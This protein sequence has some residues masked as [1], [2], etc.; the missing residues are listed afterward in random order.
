MAELTG[1]SH[2]VSPSQTP[3]A[4]FVCQW[5]SVCD[6]TGGLMIHWGS[7][8]REVMGIAGLTLLA[9]VV[10]FWGLNWGLPYLY[11]PDENVI[12]G[13]ALRMGKT[14]SL[15]PP[16]FA[17][18]PL[19]TYINLVFFGTWYVLARIVGV[20]PSPADFE[21]LYFTDPTWFYLIGRGINAT[22]GTAAIPLT[23]W[24]G[25]KLYGTAVGVVAALCLTFAFLHVQ[26]SHFATPNA[27]LP[28]FAV[29]TLLTAVAVVRS[30]SRLG[31]LVGGSLVGLAASVK[32]NAALIIT[33]LLVAHL[34]HV[35]ESNTDVDSWHRGLFN[36]WI[37][38][39]CGVVA[40]TFLACN[41]YA[42]LDCW[43]F[44]EWLGWYSSLSRTGYHVLRT[45]PGWITYLKTLPQILSWPIA[46]VAAGGVLWAVARHKREDVL[47]L[48]FPLLYVLL[49]GFSKL[50]AG[51]YL[52]PIFPA[53][54]LLA[55]AF[56]VSA[57]EQMAAWRSLQRHAM[58]ILAGVTV[59]TLALPAY[60]ALR[61]DLLITRPDTRTLAKEWIERNLPE[62]T[63]IL[64]DGFGPQLIP[65]KACIR[66]W[67]ERN[68]DLVYYKARWLL[69]RDDSDYPQP[70]Y[71]LDFLE[72]TESLT[73]FE[74]Y[75]K[76]LS[77]GGGK[78][79]VSTQAKGFDYVV[80]TS[81]LFGRYSEPERRQQYTEYAAAL[82]RFLTW[83][84][85][86][87]DLV[88]TFRPTLGSEPLDLY[89]YI[90]TTP[91]AYLSCLQRPG[92]TVYIYR[93]P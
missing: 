11:H 8:R 46:L 29:L 47:V 52:M 5:D 57:V 82:D 33:P 61:H 9:A 66:D 69:E 86:E 77:L 30:G 84:G 72:R 15:R 17:Y 93:L 7:H 38:L 34:Y 91:S 36:K 14:F 90:Q 37:F 49:M 88:Q 48:S 2:R 4:Q 67:L 50:V 35:L 55:A 22:L 78:G 42:L 74:H 21:T 20:F 19:L 45:E 51:R 89:R 28:L 75:G 39:M 58:L 18:P 87:A 64:T 68:P 70:A 59:L 43:R 71:Y 12:V 1:T 13:Y 56:L 27:V 53:L 3:V 32:Y 6:E 79:Y 40:F 73:S 23:Y 65:D 31:Y 41:P 26:E 83:L 10:R 81:I 80:L 25:R 63:R 92:P 85:S 16:D 54:A 62:D 44:L 76:E 60:N 24:V